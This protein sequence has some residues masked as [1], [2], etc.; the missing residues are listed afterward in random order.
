M[1]IDKRNAT[2]KNW[3]IKLSED[4]DSF[5]VSQERYM[6]SIFERIVIDSK[7]E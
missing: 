6:K 5:V 3:E 4:G 1:I 7:M 2:K